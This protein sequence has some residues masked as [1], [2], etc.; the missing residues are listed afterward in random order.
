MATKKK[1]AKAAKKAARK[2]RQEQ[3][4][5]MKDRKLAALHNAALEYAE[6]RDERQELT[7]KESD[8]Q[9]T[10]LSLMHK[11]KKEHYEYAGVECNL[12]VEKEKV[13]V[14]VKKAQVD[15]E[16]PEI[17]EAEP[18]ETGSETEEEEIEGDPTDDNMEEAGEE[19]AD[20]EF[21]EVG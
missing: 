12:V 13:K 6:I 1:A 3:L 5:G 10:L 21:E 4:P 14:R 11:A 16:P 2:P 9:K 18:P 7:K 8:L 20:E 19:V 17:E 15:E